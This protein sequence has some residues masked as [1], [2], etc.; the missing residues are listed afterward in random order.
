MNDITG[1]LTRFRAKKYAITSD[2]EKAFLQIHLH[3]KDRDA[4]IFL[5]LKEPSDPNS[6]LVTYSFE[7]V[8]FGATCSQFILSATLLKH[9]NE[10]PGKLSDTLEDGLYVDNI[11]SSFED[12]KS[13]I[14]FYRESRKLLQKGG[15][16][17]RS[18]NSNSSNLNELARRKK[19]T[20]PI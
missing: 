17:L 1:I 2:L 10:H 9:F 15:F 8:P 5:W 12:E 4:T 19:H 14:N 18:W 7:S 3:E 13:A 16:N 11:L 6:K 20:R